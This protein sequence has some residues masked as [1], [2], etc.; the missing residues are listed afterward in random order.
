MQLLL[1]APIAQLLCSRLGK[2]HI[3]RSGTYRM[4]TPADS[5]RSV[6]DTGNYAGVFKRSAGEWKIA[7]LI[8][9]SDLPP[10]PQVVATAHRTKARW[11]KTLDLGSNQLVMPG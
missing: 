10:Q 1:F 8:F 3:P 9:N 7:Y 6:D 4:S 11:M 5:G 2:T